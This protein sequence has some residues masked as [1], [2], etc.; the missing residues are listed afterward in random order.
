[1]LACF[2]AT[3]FDDIINN[4]YFHDARVLINIVL[5]FPYLRFGQIELPGELGALAANDVLAPLELQFEPVQ[6]LGRKG[7]PRSLGPVQVEAFRQHNLPDGAFGVCATLKHNN[8]RLKS[9]GKMIQ[10]A[11]S[12]DY[13]ASLTSELSHQCVFL[14]KKKIMINKPL[15]TAGRKWAHGARLM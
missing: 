5:C 13:C 2:N 6:L 7:G 15:F 12:L 1:M 8:K 11:P 3:R 10:N 14:V 9:W 4:T